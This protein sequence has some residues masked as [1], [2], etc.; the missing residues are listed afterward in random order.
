[1]ANNSGSGWGGGRRRGSSAKQRRYK[2][3]RLKNGRY[4]ITS[5]RPNYVTVDDND[6]DYLPF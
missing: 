3:G 4:R 2:L 1:M 6:D 5:R